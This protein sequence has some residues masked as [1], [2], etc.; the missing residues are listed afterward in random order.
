M[1]GLIITLKLKKIK[2]FGATCSLTNHRSEY[3]NTC[4]HLARL[5]QKL[6]NG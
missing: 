6:L 2:F 4:F 1:K 5:V 3:G